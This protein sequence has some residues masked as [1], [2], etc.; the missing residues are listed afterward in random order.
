VTVAC[1]VLFHGLDLPVRF[2]GVAAP[3]RDQTA[4]GKNQ[5]VV[6]KSSRHLGEEALGFVQ[7]AQVDMAESDEVLEEGAWRNV[8]CVLAEEKRGRM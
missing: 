8:R 2:D 6:R 3:D 7:P 1:S 5:D 4:E